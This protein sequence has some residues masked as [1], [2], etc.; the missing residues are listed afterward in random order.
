MVK[1]KRFQPLAV[2]NEKLKKLDIFE[3]DDLPAHRHTTV[4]GS[5]VTPNAHLTTP[6][7]PIK[8][9]PE[10]IVTRDHWQRQTPNGACSDPLCGKRLGNVAGNINCRKC[11]KLF[12][13]EHTM[14]QMKLSRTA[15][16]DTTRGTWS[17]VCETCYKSRDGYSDSTGEQRKCS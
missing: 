10:I 8:I 5:V 3:D 16:H 9:E 4:P 6:P 1:A 2:L 17:R 12:C 7:P 15:Q 14:Y 13:E 11:G